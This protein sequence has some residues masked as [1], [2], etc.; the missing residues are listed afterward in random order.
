MCFFKIYYLF[1]GTKEQCLK[2]EQQMIEDEASQF[3][4]YMPY[5]AEEFVELSSNEEPSGNEDASQSE[6]ENIP[7]ARPKKRKRVRKKVFL[8]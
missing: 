3:D 5:T 1:L 4:T 2:E 6:V 7:D 8:V